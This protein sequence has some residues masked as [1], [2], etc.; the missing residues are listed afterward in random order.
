MKFINVFR[1][2]GLSISTL[3]ALP[4]LFSTHEVLIA[5]SFIPCTL[6]DH[7]CSRQKEIK[8][9]WADSKLHG[10]LRELSLYLCPFLVPFL[11]STTMCT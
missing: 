4:K 8:L 1:T 10:E 6:L 2:K 11:F 3:E 7:F 9:P 5:Q